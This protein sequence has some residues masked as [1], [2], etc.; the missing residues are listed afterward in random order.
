ML[1][2]ICQLKI[3]ISKKFPYQAFKF[4]HFRK[5]VTQNGENDIELWKQM[6]EEIPN[7]PDIMVKICRMFQPLCNL[8]LLVASQK[9]A[10]LPAEVALDWLNKALK[11]VAYHTEHFATIKK[12]NENEEEEKSSSVD[13]I[14][15][16]DNRLYFG[17]DMGMDGKPKQLPS[18][19]CNTESSSEKKSRIF[20]CSHFGR[21][22]VLFENQPDGP[23]DPF[24]CFG[25]EQNIPEV[26][27]KSVRSTVHAQYVVLVILAGSKKILRV[28]STN[29]N[30]FSRTGC[31]STV[32][33]F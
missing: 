25:G 33:K 31:F 10:K 7:L 14:F 28:L 9:N 29:F 6:L 19:K 30:I 26:I 20:D 17:G 27:F 24:F 21:R 18:T 3:F 8:Y 1:A 12:E 4:L 11:V 16:R 2:K 32:M 13:D 15:K 22:H 5:F 23:A